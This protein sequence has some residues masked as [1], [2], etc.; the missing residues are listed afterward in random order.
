MTMQDT[1]QPQPRPQL[2]RSDSEELV[3]P[4]LLKAVAGLVIATLLM[5]TAAVML[6][7]EPAGQ[8][9]P[10]PVI[11]ERSV[12]V[13]AGDAGAA[14]ITDPAGGV[15]ADLGPGEAG[16]ITG[17]ER[18]LARQRMQHGVPLHAPVTLTRHENGRFV[19][20]DPETGWSIELTH[21]GAANEA[22]WAQLLPPA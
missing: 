11:A 1:R 18:G 3:P 6:G 12:I 8:P 19:L 13:Y 10:S 22:N 15:I 21:F 2:R 7:V 20:T 14:L 16:F 9:E 5:V 17:V 4:L